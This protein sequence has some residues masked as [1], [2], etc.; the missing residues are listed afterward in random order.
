MILEIV[1]IVFLILF[2]IVALILLVPFQISASGTVKGS[3]LRFNLKLSWLGITLWRTKQGQVKKEKEQ[4]ESKKSKR[5]PLRLISLFLESIPAI[6]ILVRSVRR[7]VRIRHLRADL[8]IGTG[9]AADT[10]VLAGV[11]WSLVSLLGVSFPMAD[12]SVRPDLDNASLDALLN[13]D[14]T[15]RVGFVLAGFVRAYTKRPFRQ[16]VSEIRMIR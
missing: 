3:E 15:I 1:A 16:F 4:V 7:A 9:D 12:F 13:A 6:E 8:V 10:A 2:L 5:R 11:L 14:A